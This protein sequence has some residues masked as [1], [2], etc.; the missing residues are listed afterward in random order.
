MEKTIQLKKK[1]IIPLNPVKEN[2]VNRIDPTVGGETCNC[3]GGAC[4]TY[5]VS[6]VNCIRPAEQANA[7]C[8]DWD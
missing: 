8:F 3:T 4:S 7:I 1:L 5:V 6:C 2:H